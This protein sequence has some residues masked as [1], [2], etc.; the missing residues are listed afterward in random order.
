V[1]APDLTKAFAN[2]QTG[3]LSNG[4]AYTL[5][6][7]LTDAAGNQ[8]AVSTNSFAVTVDTAAPSAAAITSVTDDVA[9]V[10]GTLTG[11]ARTNDTDLTVKV[12]LTGTGA[13]AGDTVQLYD[14][15]GTGSQLGTSYTLTDTDITHGSS[16][17]ATHE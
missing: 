10:T 12:S 13:V 16:N 11:G 17:T 5:T 15:S 8:S 6:A 7:R 1:T 2:V 3:T 4:T 14:G 9:P